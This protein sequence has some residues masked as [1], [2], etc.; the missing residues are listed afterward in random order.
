MTIAETVYI[1]LAAAYGESAFD[2]LTIPS[3]TPTPT[4]VVTGVSPTS[5]TIGTSVTVNRSNFGAT[6][7]GSSVRFNGAS[8]SSITSWSATQIVAVVPSAASTGPVTVVVNSTGS[9]KDYVFAFYHPVMTSATP[10]AAEVGGSITLKGTGF[11]S[12]QGSSQ[13]TFNGVTPTVRSRSGTSVV[14]LVPTHA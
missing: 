3:G 14:A 4:P 5:G 11:G 12:T 2:N 13:V 7:G 8:A 6:Q 9:N 10:P 1:G